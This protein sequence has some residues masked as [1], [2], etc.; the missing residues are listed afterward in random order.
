MTAPDP[1]RH[2]L[3]RALFRLP[4][5]AALVGLILLWEF[6]A[7]VWLPRSDPYLATL[8]PPPTQVF[9][10]AVELIR[11]GELGFHLLASLKRE[12]VAFLFA[13]AAVPLGLLMGW[14][15]PIHA[16]LDPIVEV[17]RPIPPLA[18]IPLSILWFGIGDA[19]NQFIIFLGMFF[20]ILI[21]TI[22]G[23]A[24][25]EPVLVRAARS[26]GAGEW[27]VIKRVVLKAALPQI[28]TGVRVGLGVGW[29]ALVAA[30][31]VGASSGLGFMINDARSVLRTDIIV[32]GMI[33]IGFVGLVIDMLL[34][35]AT[36]KLLPWSVSNAK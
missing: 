13:L 5:L 16:Q 29:M 23:V 24:K 34:R 6:V 11:S 17:L 21:N 22:D 1:A 33:T 19:Q 26:L 28:V 12:A 36:R 27:K 20:P 3:L 4:N 7:S 15:R 14:F 31:L 2:W 8:M 10:T 25:V 32:V 18:W 30:E 9:T 35:F